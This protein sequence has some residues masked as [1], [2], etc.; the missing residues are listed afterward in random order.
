MSS[1]REVNHHDHLPVLR[2]EVVAHL[3]VHDARLVVDG[4]FGRGGHA[5]ALLAQ[6]P[7][8]ARF[9]G[10]DRDPEA[11]AAG[12]AL[13]QED[14]RFEMVSSPFSALEAVLSERGVGSEVDALLLDIGVSS[15]QLDVPS[16]GFSFRVDGPLDMRMN[17]LAGLSAAQWLASVGETELANTLYELGEER[18]SRRIARAIVRRRELEPFVGTADLARTVAGA[19]G[20]PD[21]GRH[22]ATRTFQAIRMRINAELDELRSALHTAPAVLAQGG[23]LAVIS[24]HSLEDRIVKHFMRLQSRGPEFPRGLP[25]PTD[26]PVPPFGRVSKAI[27]ASAQE[28]AV[29][30]RARSATLR[31]AEMRS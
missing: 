3:A 16:R 5:R 27:R 19:Y 28:L 23:R 10:L 14:S 6:M 29:N 26:A 2:D 21:P 8:G 12:L 9:I 4:T 25:P 24:F 20:K 17:P 11:V 13:A 22:P 7:Q 18:K 1:D 31:I 30:P 15:P